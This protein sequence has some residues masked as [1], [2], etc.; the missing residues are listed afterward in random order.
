MSELDGSIQSPSKRIGKLRMSRQVEDIINGIAKFDAIR[1][2]WP[3]LDSLVDELKASPTPARGIDALFGVF[4]RHPGTSSGSGVLWTV[5]HTL[6]AL[7]GYEFKLVESLRRRPSV[8]AVMMVNRLLNSGVTDVGEDSLI[9]LL[10]GIKSN[11]RTQ[12]AVKAEIESV[13]EG[14]SS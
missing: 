6:E 10:E 1:D 14:R 4:E 7:P 2:G 12:R 13:L 11:Q 5:L 8:L 9:E 3:K